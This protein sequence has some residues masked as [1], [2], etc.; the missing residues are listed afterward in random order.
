MFWTKVN[1][2]IISLLLILTL[3]TF[4]S[5][6]N[7]DVI[8]GK[9]ELV[10]KK[11]GEYSQ[12]QQ[13]IIKGSWGSGVGEFGKDD[14]AAEIG[15]LSFTVD[16]EENIYILDQMN[17]RVQKFSHSGDFIAS[18]QIE[19]KIADDIAVDDNGN[20]YIMDAVTKKAVYKYTPYG[21]KEQTFEINPEIDWV[22]GLFIK[23]DGIYIEIEH[24]NLCLIGKTNN[25]SI[26]K[27]IQNDPAKNEP[28]PG[29]FYKGQNSDLYLIARKENAN[30]LLVEG[31]TRG[32]HILNQMQVVADRPVREIM[33]LDSDTKGN[34]YLTHKLVLEGPAPNFEC[35]AKQLELVKFTPDGKLVGK[36]EMP[37]PVSAEYLK[38]IVVSN[39]GNIYQLQTFDDGLKVVKWELE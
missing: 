13:V 28:F 27:I 22:T 21:I 4:I 32:K 5:L 23:D 24:D 1:I 38:S 37:Y 7:A 3:T 6:V 2:K 9:V 26:P 12:G 11:F 17:Q 33:S 29:R 19:N 10:G 16:K 35:L 30:E 31:V 39:E 20:I 36:I 18:F 34:V 15:P 14:V 8:K 25:E